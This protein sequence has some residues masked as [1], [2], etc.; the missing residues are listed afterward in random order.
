MLSIR[1]K[2]KYLGINLITFTGT[3][4]EKQSM[5][6]VDEGTNTIYDIISKDRFDG[7][8]MYGGAI[9][10]LVSSSDM[11]DF[12]HKYQIP[13]VNI[14]SEIP[15]IPSIIASNY[16]GV[17]DLV[18]HLIKVHSYT[19]IGF[20]KGPDGHIEAEERYR[21]Y[22]TA[23]K[24]NGLEVGLEYVFKGNFSPQA[25]K[26]AVKEFLFNRPVDIEAFVCVDDDTAFGV[27]DELH[28]WGLRV[29][30]DI[31]LVGFD[32]AEASANIYPPLTTVRQPFAELGER[33][34]DMLMDLI[35]GKDF[36]DINYLPSKPVI[37]DSCGCLKSLSTYFPVSKDEFNAEDIKKS[38][39]KEIVETILEHYKEL[40]NLTYS[41]LYS[42][43]E[44][45]YDA[46]NYGEENKLYRSFNKIVE[47]IDHSKLQLL[48][49]FLD[50]CSKLLQVRSGRYIESEL[51]L[52]KI[53]VR[54]SIN[55]IQDKTIDKIVSRDRYFHLNDINQNLHGALSIDD[56]F[57]DV[58]NTLPDIGIKKF[59]IVASD[60][61]TTISK[62]VKLIYGYTEDGVVDLNDY[63]NSFLSK[64]ILPDKLLHY[65]DSD[66]M[67]MT[68]SFNNEVFGYMVVDVEEDASELTHAICW[69]FSSSLKRISILEERNRKAIELEEALGTLKETQ[70]QLI[71]S[72]KLSSLGS[73]VAGVA[74]EINTPLGIVVTSVSY[75]DELSKQI[76]SLYNKNN[77]TKS[78]MEEY[79]L[80]LEEILNT[81]MTSA[82][83]A[84]ALVKSF[85]K[86]AVDQASEE[87]RTFDLDEY[88]SET[89]A[90]LKANFKEK[91][92]LL[93][94]NCIDDI[95]ITSYPG[96]I[97]QIITNL[98]NNS[99]D[100]G[101]P[102]N[103]KGKILID[104][105][106][107]ADN[108]SI[109]FHDNG[110]GIEERF[111]NKIYEPFFTS[112][113]ESGRSGLGL[114][115][116]HNLVTQVLNGS[117]K[118]TSTIDKGTTFV[119]DFPKSL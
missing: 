54:S 12:C 19:K 48:N 57:E 55:F 111:I 29:P 15:H 21:G 84:V 2:L 88:I 34:V 3:S 8:I 82:K 22:K 33:A 102:D 46:I 47:S 90:A 38:T 42:F 66:W 51:L 107:H 74:H 52:E 61:V 98:I 93:K 49:E 87:K 79:F 110:K 117:I 27:M 69:H 31:A 14:S 43:L 13:I 85:K 86:V 56:L 115:I 58:Y 11:E 92:I 71:Q 100:H 18:T 65:I 45:F 77:L 30:D 97:S 24:D 83:R 119:I 75:I 32:D 28:R 39:Q 50:Y 64:K 108:V 105:K 80:N 70:E 16:D 35:K 6:W 96:A 81:T 62:R 95:Y 40:N 25:G 101:F 41:K 17:Y 9:G 106:S 68:L 37:R 114:H 60:D 89:L 4:L 91:D 59:F 7:V 72:E 116:V 20:V 23:L 109:I 104:I 36:P 1:K 73:M 76:I 78:K 26:E 10:Q 103:R 67:V 44:N 5:K 53:K 112:R 113:R 94:V 63:R 99:M 118:V